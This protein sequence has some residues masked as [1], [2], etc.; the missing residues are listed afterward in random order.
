[1]ALP[2]QPIVMIGA[3]RSGTKIVRDLLAE[4]PDVDCVPYDV[5]YIWRMGN[6]DVP[7]DEMTPDMVTP[8]VRDKI[9]RNLE[10]W[11]KGA[12]FFLEK[13]VSTCLRVPFAYAVFPE[14]KYIH[15]LRDGRDVVE[16]VQRNWTSSPDW[17]YIF[18]KART[19]PV[20]EAFGY[21]L[22]YASTNVRKIFVKDKSSIGTWGVRYK[23][24]DEDHS[25]KDLIE[26]CAMQWVYCIQKAQADIDVIPADQLITVRYEQLIEDPESFLTGIAEFAGLD[27]A[28]YRE[29]RVLGRIS[30]KNVGKGFRTMSQEQIDLAMPYLQDTLAELGYV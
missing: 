30:P 12:P 23:G 21:G 8:E 7:H 6:E 4:H 10:A 17:G 2:Y 27:P 29:D 11:W 1:M 13:T 3:A 22:E 26:V 16:S 15:L 14:A 18:E 5:N 19:F 24:I 28:P 20:R 25:N 9:I